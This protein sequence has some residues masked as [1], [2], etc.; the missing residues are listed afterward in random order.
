[1]LVK[2]EEFTRLV[3]NKSKLF[4]GGAIALGVSAVAFQY[5]NAKKIPDLSLSRSG[6]VNSSI[7]YQWQVPQQTVDRLPKT[8][9]IYR[10]VINNIATIRLVV[11]SN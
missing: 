5:Q 6:I 11:N 7:T 2:I 10:F 1:M 8:V 9:P 4:L 3:M